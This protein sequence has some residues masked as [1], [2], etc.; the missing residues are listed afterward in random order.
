MK[1]SFLL[2]FETVTSRS[3]NT[4]H[5]FS[6]AKNIL[7]LIISSLI[8]IDGQQLVLFKYHYCLYGIWRHTM[9]WTEKQLAI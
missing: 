3:H 6:V 7:T 8:L 2:D 1:S 4:G 9:Y 5:L